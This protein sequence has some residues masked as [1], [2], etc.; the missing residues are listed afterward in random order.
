MNPR[1]ANVKPEKNYM[2]HIRF[3]NGEEVFFDVKPYLDCEMFKQLKNI[4]FFNS[5]RPAYGTIQWANEVD[6]CP[7]TVYLNSVKI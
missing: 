5:V 2:L 7:D 6:F 1:V 4:D 3:R